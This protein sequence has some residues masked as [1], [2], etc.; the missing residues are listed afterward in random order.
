[1]NRDQA[2]I[3][4]DELMTEY[5]TLTMNGWDQFTDKNYQR[6]RDQMNG[7]FFVS[8]FLHALAYISQANKLK[9]V[10]YDVSSYSFKHAAERW[11]GGT[12]C[13]N[14]DGAEPTYLPCKGYVSNGAFICAAIAS[15][16]KVKR[17]RDPTYP[18][19]YVNLVSPPSGIC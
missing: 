17:S 4:I 13:P 19:C 12:G 3:V 8:Q 15:T 18:N 6:M 2:Q 5:P 7:D 9:A 14:Y 1:M 16:L 10:N 11:G